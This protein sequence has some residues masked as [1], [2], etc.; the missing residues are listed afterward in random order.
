[1]NKL[2]KEIA[3]IIHYLKMKPHPEG[4]FY[5]LLFEDTE[6]ISAKCLPKNYKGSRPFWN[7]IYYLLPS[8]SKSIFHK[9]TMNEMWN[10]YLGGSLELFDLSPE[11]PLK[12]IILGKN[13]FSGE[14][15]SYIFPKGHWIGARPLIKSTFSLVSCVTC[16]G[17][18]FLDWEKGERDKLVQKYPNFQQLIIDLTD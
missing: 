3:E 6:K 8:G 13:I 17:F 4:G 9:I 12:R 14:Q 7:A 16:P 5:S 18:T 2:E 1:M 11:G 10:H 15:L